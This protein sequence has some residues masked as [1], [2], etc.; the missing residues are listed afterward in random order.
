MKT[1]GEYIKQ[2]RL[3]KRISRKKLQE[4]TKIRSE[5]IENIEN[6]N[7][8]KLPEGP[9][10]LGFIKNISKSLNI[11][12]KHATALFR[13]DYREKELRINPKPDLLKRFSWSPKTTFIAVLSVILVAISAYLAYQYYMFISPPELV[14]DVPSEGQVVE[15]NILTVSGKTDPESLVSVNEQPFI[16]EEDGTF[17]SEIEISMS[18]NTITVKSVSRSGKE[19]VVTRKIIYNK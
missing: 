15:E 19:T 13:R 3:K 6:G 9:V 8:S 16:I 5:F 7:W 11:D 14:V 17:S 10:V 4:M 18:T 1:I 12:T 2:N